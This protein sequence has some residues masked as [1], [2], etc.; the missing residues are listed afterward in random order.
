VSGGEVN[1][2]HNRYCASEKWKSVMV[3]EILPWVLEDTQLTGPV[4]EVGPGPG[5]VTEALVRYGVE[6]LTTLEIEQGAADRLRSRFGDAVRV[7]TGDGEDMALPDGGFSTV[8]CC[9]MLHHV[10]TTAGQDAVLHEAFRVL[11]PGGVLAGSDSRTSMR[12]RIYHIRDVFNPVDPG[13]LGD[14]LEAAGFS[15]VQ[16]DATESRFRFR[17]VKS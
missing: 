16:V 3:G 13:G 4:L 17:A 12:M 14:R 8:L 6:D 1:R 15:Q 11:Q 7:V 5:L 10:P 2:F 9:T